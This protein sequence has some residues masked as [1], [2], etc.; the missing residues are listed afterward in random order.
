[1]D[2][3][4]C[5]RCGSFYLSEEMVCCNCKEKDKSDGVKLKSFLEENT[6]VCSLEELSLNT[7]V[8]LKN[9]NRYFETGS[10]SDII[11]NLPGSNDV[12]RKY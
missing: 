10:Y 3:K 5:A 12:D 9:L 11:S 6:E 1:M 8:S 4:K 7:G 2:F